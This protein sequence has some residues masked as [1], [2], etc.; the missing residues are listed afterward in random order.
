[1]AWSAGDTL[2]CAFT[3]P[4]LALDV[5]FFVAG[6]VVAVISVVSGDRTSAVQWLAAAAP[7]VDF[8]ASSP[9]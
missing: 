1:M 3:V 6:A 7:A 8:G 2:R 9:G 5:V 4:W